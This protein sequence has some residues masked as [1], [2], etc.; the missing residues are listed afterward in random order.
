MGLRRQPD[1]TF[2][3]LLDLKNSF[4][5]PT[6]VIALSVREKAGLVSQSGFS[7]DDPKA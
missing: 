7:E 6:Q 2:G 1:P 5:E 3:H 4:S